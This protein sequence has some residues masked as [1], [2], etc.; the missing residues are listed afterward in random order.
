M[1]KVALVG[2][3]TRDP[4][5]KYGQ[6]GMAICS[7]SLAVKRP[8]SKEDKADFPMVTCF[9]KIAEAVANYQTKGSLV[10][11]SGIIATDKYEKD[12]RV[13]YKTEVLAD[14]VEFLGKKDVAERQL[15]HADPGQNDWVKL[16][17]VID[18][19]DNNVPF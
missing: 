13:I 7:F 6:Q 3:L 2:R 8:R 19:R 1:N 16:G 9:G 14:E 4:E 15:E 12:G 17:R 18:Q 5:L 10:A 11:V